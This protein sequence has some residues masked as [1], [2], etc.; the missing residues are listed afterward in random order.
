MS[1]FFAEKVYEVTRQI[2]KGTVATYG[3]IARLV[4]KPKA[5]RAVGYYMKKNPYAPK[6][7]CHRVVSSDGD[8]TGYS[9]SGGI[10]AKRSLLKKEG[11]LFTNKKVNLLKSQWKTGVV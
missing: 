6:V 10:E 3:Q 7:P 9:L 2:P 5:A 4:G 1:H 8:L 11:V